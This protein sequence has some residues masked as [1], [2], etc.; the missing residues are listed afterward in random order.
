M[1]GRGGM[2]IEQKKCPHTSKL[3]VSSEPAMDRDTTSLTQGVAFGPF[4]LFVGQRLLEKAGIPI[5]LGSRALDIL[6][7]L[8]ERAG[9]VV[10]KEEL[11]SRVWPNVTVDENRLRVHVAGLRKVLGDGQAG[12]RYVTN[13]S[14]RGYC[15]VAP[16]VPLA[17]PK[18]ASNLD[19]MISD[20]AH[21][22]PL[23]LARMVGRDEAVRTISD[24]LATRFVTIQ[25]P[26]GIGKTTV[27]VSVGHA[28]LAAF[29]GA[30]RFVDLGS[31]QDPGLV[32]G[33]VASALGL[34]VGSTDPTS[35]LISFLRDRRMLLIL[36][37]CEHVI[38]AVAALAERVFQ[39]AAQIS[40]LATSREALRV[41]GEHVYRLSALESPPEGAE[42]TAMQV[43]AFPAAHLF[44][45]R[46]SAGSHR[47]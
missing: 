37:C 9:N 1:P 29:E 34:P 40:I 27:A 38:E 33:A 10:S 24:L 41:E 31:L 14:G 23:R 8:V 25:G 32:P 2:A 26:G 5:A 42:L 21:R 17:E 45:E 43:L 3:P 35:R 18:V 15:F 30:V 4:R 11:I 39:E 22:L 28:Q 46:A 6:I 19:L 7:F 47:F 12:Y 16:I 36:D 20:Q 13:I 44:V